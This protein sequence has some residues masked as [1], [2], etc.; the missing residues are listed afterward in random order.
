[1]EE[2]RFDGRVAIVT[3][4]GLET[5]MGAHHAKMLAARGAKVV[6]HDLAANAA[7]AQHVVEQ[8]EADGGTAVVATGD[9][10]SPTD[11]EDVVAACVER[12]GR[13]DIVINNAGHAGGKSWP[14]EDDFEVFTH[15]VLVHLG[16]AFNVSRAAWRHFVS[17]GYGRLVNISSS[18][19]LGMVA[20]MGY[21]GDPA[22]AGKNHGASYSAA[23]AGMIGLT[24]CFAH[25]AP[26]L[27]IKA[28]IVC[29][30]AA[31][32][33]GRHSVTR[34]ATGQ[35]IPLY[36][37][38]ISSGVTYLCHESCPANGEMF[39]LGGGRMDR[40]AIVATQGYVHP[41]LT[42]ELVAENWDRIVD[43]DNYWIPEN[44]WQHGERKRQDRAAILANS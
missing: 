42:P 24:R 44:N 31:T 6:V 5:G 4:A 21:T 37:H 26:G 1:L 28:N 7:E 9:V 41:E 34:L 35:T 20:D 38:L 13:V 40:L 32:H 43:L 16:G 30:T 23:K 18:A 11:T 15:M 33:R 12:F 27:D 2:L 8:I 39:G 36:P 3:G 17:Q 29:P 25:Y 19:L 14:D 10:S 22:R